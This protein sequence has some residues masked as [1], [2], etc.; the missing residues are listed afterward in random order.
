MHL[1]LGQTLFIAVQI[2]GEVDHQIC[3]IASNIDEAFK[4]TVNRKSTIKLRFK[5][6]LNAQVLLFLEEEYYKSDYSCRSFKN[7]SC[8]KVNLLKYKTEW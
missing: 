5:V 7:T 6:V 8:E 3:S 1:V 4:I 2:V